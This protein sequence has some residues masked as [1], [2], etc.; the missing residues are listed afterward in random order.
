[1]TPSLKA[2]GLIV[3]VYT[4]LGLSSCGRGIHSELLFQRNNRFVI[5]R[6]TA[7]EHIGEIV[8]GA[9][10]A[11]VIKIDAPPGDMDMRDVFEALGIYSEPGL[12]GLAQAI[13]DRGAA[14][15]VE[16]LVLDLL[17]Q[18]VFHPRVFDEVFTRAGTNIIPVLTGQ[19]DRRPPVTFAEVSFPPLAPR[20]FE[21]TEQFERLD[22][23]FSYVNAYHFVAGDRLLV[24]D[25][26][27]RTLL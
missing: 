2:S 11:T 16:Q 19:R 26:F 18:F 17:G 23:R 25:T 1:M 10:E 4:S 8:P 3:P 27:C 5:D 21:Q 7:A 9:E 20:P 24:A 13:S 22:V 15:A 6:A 12:N 14:V